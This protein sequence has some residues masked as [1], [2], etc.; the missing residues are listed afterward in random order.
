M[1]DTNININCPICGGSNNCCYGKDKSLGEC[2][3]TE[4]TFPE[5]IFAYVESE[6]IRKACICKNCLEKY[7]TG[8]LFGRPLTSLSD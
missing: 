2:W 1:T 5:G 3:C 6:F 7:K 4:E 8:T